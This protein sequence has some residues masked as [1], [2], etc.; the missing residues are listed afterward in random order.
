M[1]DELSLAGGSDSKGVQ[2]RSPSEETGT[3]VN[4]KDLQT[5]ARYTHARQTPTTGGSLPSTGL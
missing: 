5:P 1:R 2:S 4:V 3:I